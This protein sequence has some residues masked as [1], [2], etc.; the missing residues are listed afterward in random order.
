MNWVSFS[1][2]AFVISAPLTIYHFGMFSPYSALTTFLLALP[3]AAV[4]ITGHLSLATMAILPSVSQA[5]G[6][7]SAFRRAAGALRALVAVPADAV[8]SHPPGQPVVGFA[9]LR[10]GRR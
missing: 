4:L 8:H 9:L 2:V 6:D 5:L 10:A 1:V 7:C 3:V